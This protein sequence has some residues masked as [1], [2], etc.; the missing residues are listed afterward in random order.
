[1]ILDLP[2]EIQEHIFIWILVLQRWSWHRV[3][4][5]CLLSSSLHQR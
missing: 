5:S 2:V 4:F 1:L 3:V